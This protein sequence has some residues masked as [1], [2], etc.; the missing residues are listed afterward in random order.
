MLF[1]TKGM[2]MISSC[3]QVVSFSHAPCH[4]SKFGCGILSISLMVLNCIALCLVM[5]CCAQL[6]HRVYT[7]LALCFDLWC[8]SECLSTL[9]YC[10]L[11]CGAS[12][13]GFLQYCAVLCCPVLC[14]SVR[15]SSSPHWL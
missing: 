8:I 2:F 10:A 4:L 13:H 14:A 3:Q 9:L 6:C 12:S 11:L 1:K 15:H 7:G 5:P